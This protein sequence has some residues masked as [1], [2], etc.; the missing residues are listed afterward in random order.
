MASCGVRVRVRVLRPVGVTFRRGQSTTVDRREKRGRKEGEGR[1][2]GNEARHGGYCMQ[3]LSWSLW[4][5]NDILIPNHLAQAGRERGTE[6]ERQRILEWDTHRL[7]THSFHVLPKC[8]CPNC[9]CPCPCHWAL[10]LPLP[11]WQSRPASPA[12]TTVGHN[13]VGG[14]GIKGTIAAARAIID[15]HLSAISLWQPQRHPHLGQGPSLLLSL[16][17]CVSVLIE[18]RTIKMTPHCFIFI[19]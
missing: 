2:M 13:F 19:A 12:A 6:R 4:A 17:V 16:C 11:L 8:L 14:G 7:S 10:P 9:L 18:K 5:I 3:Y 1:E 15:Y